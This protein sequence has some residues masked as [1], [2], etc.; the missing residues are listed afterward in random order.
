MQPPRDLP[1]ANDRLLPFVR[2]AVS[3]GWRIFRSGIG[4]IEVLKA[5]LPPIH[6]GLRISNTTAEIL[7][8]RLP[9]NRPGG[10]DKQEDRDA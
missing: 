7:E 8:N 5:G 6:I 9:D 10:A 1:G 4:N 2:F 3:D